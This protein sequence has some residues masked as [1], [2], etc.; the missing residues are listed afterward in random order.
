MPEKVYVVSCEMGPGDDAETHVVAAF[1]G[2]SDAEEFSRMAQ[3]HS[4]RLTRMSSEQ[5]AAE[6]NPFDPR[7]YWSPYGPVFYCVDSVPLVSSVGH[8]LAAI[9]KG[10]K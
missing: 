2:E 5:A 7:W 10:K 6:G 8:A 1:S 3:E 4:D 9:D